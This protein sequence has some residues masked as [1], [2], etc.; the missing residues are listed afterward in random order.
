[1]DALRVLLLIAA[2]GGIVLWL[3]WARMYP[4]YRWYSVVPITWLLHVAMFHLWRLLELSCLSSVEL[5]QWS[6]A[7]H[8]H[9]LILL[10]AA[11]I[12]YRRVDQHD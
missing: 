10:T 3:W 9:A 4:V 1:M 5:N 6:I 8:L 12:I 11:P 7:I 2:T